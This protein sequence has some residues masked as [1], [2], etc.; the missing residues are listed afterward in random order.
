[1]ITFSFYFNSN[2]HEYNFGFVPTPLSFFMEVS[3][4]VRHFGLCGMN[5]NLKCKV[6]LLI[7]GVGLALSIGKVIRQNVL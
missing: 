7:C 3:L 1:M 5:Y 2:I 6:I 4:K